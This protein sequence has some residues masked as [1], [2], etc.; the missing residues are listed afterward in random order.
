MKQ[1][2]NTPLW[3]LYDYYMGTNLGILD[4]S[5]NY[6]LVHIH[7]D[8][9][10]L[11]SYRGV[12]NGITYDIFM[13]EYTQIEHEDVPETIMRCITNIQASKLVDYVPIETRTEH[14]AHHLA[15]LRLEINKHVCQMMKHLHDTLEASKTIIEKL[16]YPFVASEYAIKNGCKIFYKYPNADGIRRPTFEEYV[17]YIFQKI[18]P[19]PE[20]EHDH[21]AW[22]QHKIYE[23]LVAKYP[24]M[25]IRYIGAPNYIEVSMP[26]NVIG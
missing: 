13:A 9:K 25:T 18:Y 7:H 12:F 4:D 11:T 19:I 6:T 10:E 8:R 16:Y 26:L 24:Y 20:G 23:L 22:I 21:V 2:R 1:Y 3:H 15:A 14:E 17:H 5:N